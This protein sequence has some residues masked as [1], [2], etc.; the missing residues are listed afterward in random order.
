[1]II[2]CDMDG[3]LVDFPM[4]L[5]EKYPEEM[6]NNDENL[7]IPLS[8][9]DW[10]EFNSDPYFWHY[11]P[12]MK[13]AFVLWE[14][15]NVHEP[16]ILTAWSGCRKSA[17]EGKWFWCH[18]HL[19]VNEKERFNCVQREEK[20]NFAVTN[21]KANLLIDDFR[22]NIDEWVAAGGIGILHKSASETIKQL[23]LLGY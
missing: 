16:H 4:I 21:G 6:K 12:P 14:Y 22:K 9:A 19:G 11:I 8:D 23:K 15:I 2:Y 3:V 10:E 13:D 17:H 20:I 1:M 5:R 18:G 7:F